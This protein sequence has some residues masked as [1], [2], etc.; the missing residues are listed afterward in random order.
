MLKVSSS[1][2]STFTRFVLLFSVLYAAFGVTSPFLPAFLSSRG[3]APEQIGVLLALCTTIRL[4][5]GPTAARIA[6]HLQ[7]LRMVLSGC[8]VIAGLAAF[9]LVPANGF[10]TLLTLSLLHAAMLSPTTVL[11]D[12]LALRASQGGRSSPAFEYGWV[13]G[14]GS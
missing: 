13:R 4:F 12:A 7:A 11:A 10:M 14:V 6:D 9:C 8:T 2:T 1:D 3:L 5:S